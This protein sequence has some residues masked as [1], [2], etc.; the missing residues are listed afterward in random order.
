MALHLLNN[1]VSGEF[2]TPWFTGADWV[3]Y[4][5]LLAALWSAAAALLLVVRGPR[6]PRLRLEPLDDQLAV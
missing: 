4:F 3:R 5:W 1:T 2:V 6:Q